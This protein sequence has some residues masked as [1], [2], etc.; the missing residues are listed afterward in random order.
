MRNVSFV[1]ILA[2]LDANLYPDWESLNFLTI[3]IQSN[4]NLLRNGSYVAKS[5]ECS[6][7]KQGRTFFF[8][9]QVWNKIIQFFPCH[10]LFFSQARSHQVHWC[11]S[12]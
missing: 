11:T 8:I 9:K 3:E 7:Y 4:L 2:N 10:V 12:I 6:N 5:I 1:K